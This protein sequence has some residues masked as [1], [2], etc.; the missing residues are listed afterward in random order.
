MLVAEIPAPAE[1]P[2][3]NRMICKDLRGH[4]E[5]LWWQAHPNSAKDSVANR[6]SYRSRI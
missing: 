1:L 6:T 2:R 5:R 3:G 4:L